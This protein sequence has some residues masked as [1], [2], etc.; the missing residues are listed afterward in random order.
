M[1][2]LEVAESAIMVDSRS[3]HAVLTQRH[4]L[5]V[6][7]SIDDFAAGYTSLEQFKNLPISELKIDKVFILAM[8]N[9]EADVLIVRSAI[10]L[11]HNVGMTVVAGGA[12]TADAVEAL[13]DC[14]WDVVQSYH[15]CRPISATAFSA[16]YAE[17]A[18]INGASTKALVC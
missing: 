1:L 7:I 3:A 8:Q 12:E 5:G 14:R 10:N 15:S 16:W 9:D 13:A 2:I 6:R 17:R 18:Q 11:G 4:Q